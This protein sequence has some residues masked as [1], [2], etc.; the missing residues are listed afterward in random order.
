LFLKVAALPKS[1]TQFQNPY[2]QTTNIMMGATPQTSTPVPPAATVRE[3]LVA[4]ALQRVLPLHKYTLA[5]TS[6]DILSSEETTF[7]PDLWLVACFAAFIYMFFRDRTKNARLEAIEQKQE[8]WD[9]RQIRTTNALQSRDKLSEAVN[10]LVNSIEN[11]GI[12]DIFRVKIAGTLQNVTET[13]A[14]PGFRPQTPMRYTPRKAAME[15]SA[16]GEQP[17]PN[18]ATSSPRAPAATQLPFAQTQ[19]QR[20]V[21]IAA[22]SSTPLSRSK[23]VI[24][25]VRS[26]STTPREPVLPQESA[27]K[28]PA[29][30]SASEKPKA[31]PLSLSMVTTIQQSSPV[32][33]TVE[34]T[35]SETQKALAKTASDLKRAT[36]EEAK[37]AADL[38]HTG[39]VIKLLQKNLTEADTKSRTTEAEHVKLKAAHEFKIAQ[40]NS[41][42]AT[43]ATLKTAQRVALAQYNDVATKNAKLE[44]EHAVKASQ[45]AN[46]GTMYSKLQADVANL[47]N[48]PQDEEL[49][50][51]MLD[52]YEESSSEMSEDEAASSEEEDKFSGLYDRPATTV[53]SVPTTTGSTPA[54]VATLGSASCDGESSQK[55][56]SA[57]MPVFFPVSQTR[58]LRDGSSKPARGGPSEVVEEFKPTKQ[59]QHNTSTTTSDPSGSLAY[60]PKTNS[61]SEFCGHCGILPA[62]SS[63]KHRQQCKADH[64]AAKQPLNSFDRNTGALLVTPSSQQTVHPSLSPRELCGHCGVLPTGPAYKHREMCLAD[65][66]AKHLPLNTFDRKTGLPVEPGSTAQK[67]AQFSTP[68]GA[69][70]SPGQH[71]VPTL[72]SS[73]LSGNR[74]TTPDDSPTTGTSFASTTTG[75]SLLL[76]SKPTTRHSATTSPLFG[77]STVLSADSPRFDFSGAGG[78]ISPLA[79]KPASTF[80]GFTGYTSGPQASTPANRQTEQS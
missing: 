45:L 30:S 40:Y 50:D 79:P 16:L 71:H 55:L 62:G 11:C 39:K 77:P 22:A 53:P 73:G 43:Q 21:P 14:L 65:R 32:A 18:R 28:I 27:A 26:V 10:E 61:S 74:S 1:N 25:N 54:I 41:M 67:G 59:E 49:S 56:F 13:R 35:L 34:R 3:A 42:E 47:H 60:V 9:A 15:T 51:E 48:D 58:R 64:I 5:L 75:Q 38:E 4:N 69:P 6:T 52:D 57:S 23:L 2:E 76:D 66:K 7:W 80:T 70:P 72:S 19:A 8:V 29:A 68:Q 20:V 46:L 37:L 17:V 33:G 78:P 12:L 24:S 36:D 44:A 63:Y 31:N